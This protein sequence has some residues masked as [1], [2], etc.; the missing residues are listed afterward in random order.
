MQTPNLHTKLWKNQGFCAKPGHTMIL[1]SLLPLILHRVDTPEKAEAF[2]TQA[3]KFTDDLV[4]QHDVTVVVHTTDRYGRLG[5]EV[6][7]PDGRGM[8]RELGR[9]GLAWW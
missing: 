2:G 5:G 4:F 1:G 6:L 9:A 8:G 3:H 7:L